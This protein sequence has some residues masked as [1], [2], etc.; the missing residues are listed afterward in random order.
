MCVSLPLLAWVS[1][2]NPFRFETMVTPGLRHVPRVHL[3]W[4]WFLVMY[5]ILG[6]SEGRAWPKRA[7]QR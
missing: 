5:V 6:S 3:C 1:T 2:R 7:H 4:V